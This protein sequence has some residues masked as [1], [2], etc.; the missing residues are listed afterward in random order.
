MAVHLLPIMWLQITAIL[1]DKILLEVPLLS[2]T[3]RAQGSALL[4][5]VKTFKFTE[6]RRSTMPSP[7]RSSLKTPN[8][9]RFRRSSLFWDVRQ[10][11][12]VVRYRS[13]GTTYWALPQGPSSPR[14]INIIQFLLHNCGRLLSSST[15]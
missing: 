1:L 14:R 11:C 3:I 9:S 13:S 8:N 12:L 4:G 5:L 7:P 2:R 10:R 15:R 6:T